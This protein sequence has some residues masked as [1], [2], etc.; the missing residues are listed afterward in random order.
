[1]NDTL[2]LVV[3]AKTTPKRDKKMPII[4]IAQRQLRTFVEFEDTY[5]SKIRVQ[6]SSSAEGPHC[7]VFVDHPTGKEPGSA[8]HLSP[9]QA[10][11]LILGLQEFVGTGWKK[12]SEALP[13]PQET[14]IVSV[15]DKE[16]H[17]RDT[18][19]AEYVPRYSSVVDWDDFDG[20]EDQVDHNEEQDEWYWPE[21]WYFVDTV[22][23]AV[24]P[25]K[26]ADT[27]IE[28]THWMP[29]PALPKKQ[30]QVTR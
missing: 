23:G 1:M 13:L 5:G 7:W 2:A 25:C 15:K 11:K 22:D 20:E 30:N 24:T 26:I 6:A 3:E 9:E 19:L 14:V 16:R 10:Q 28:I 18:L 8:A 17:W 29:L 4:N 27:C 12:P 21:G